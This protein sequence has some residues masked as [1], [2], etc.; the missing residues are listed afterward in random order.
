MTT[1][2][3]RIATLLAAL[4]L[5]VAEGLC[6]E[7][8]WPE[9]LA[10]GT[11]SPGGTY[12][13]YGEGLARILTRELRTTAWARPTE[14]PI[15]NIKLLES[16]EI[17]LAFVTLGIAH[18]GWNGTAD[19]AE[20]KKYRAMRAAFP[21]YDTPFQFMVLRDAGILSIADLGGKR[22]GI[23]PQGGTAGTYMPDVFKTL[24]LDATLRTATWADLASQVA[25]GSIDGLAV[26]AG[27]PFPSFA[28]LERRSKV[29]YLPLTRDQIVSLRLAMPELGASL[30]AAGTYPSLLRH[31]QTVGLFNF[32]VVHSSLPDDLV[33]AI[34]EAVFASH[35]ELMAAHPAAAETVPGNFTRNTFLPYHGGA[36]QW[37]HRKSDTG[38]VRGD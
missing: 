18:Q 35:E 24:K 37:Y 33:Y 3:Y 9:T 7:P 13:V 23:G 34:V 2:A 22:V 21:M 15:E 20:S 29:R 1:H 31:Y 26:A 25:A 4:W 8:H 32:A 17:Q 11:A 10:I 38:V 5:S 6:R 27:V 16:G 28:D 36:A 19:W 12:F 14:G 30:V